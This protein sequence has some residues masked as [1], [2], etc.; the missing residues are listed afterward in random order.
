MR[1]KG[2][3]LRKSVVIVTMFFLAAV[4]FFYDVALKQIILPLIEGALDFITVNVS[5]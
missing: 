5:S 2:K 3:M 1:E 4:L